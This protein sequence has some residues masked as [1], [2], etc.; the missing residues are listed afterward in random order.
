[1]LTI[2]NLAI[3]YKDI[4]FDDK[5]SFETSIRKLK[6]LTNSNQFIIYENNSY[7]F[8]NQNCQIVDTIKTKLFNINGYL[9]R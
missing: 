1:M 2:V 5:S 8:H 6:Q 7:F 3:I 9:I 4:I